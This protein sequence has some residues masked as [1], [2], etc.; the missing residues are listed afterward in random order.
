MKCP[1][2]GADCWRNEVDVGVGVI[3]DEWKCTECLWDENQAFPMNAV[4]WENFLSVDDSDLAVPPMSPT[5]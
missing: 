2:C 5:E 4:D 1:E 3:T